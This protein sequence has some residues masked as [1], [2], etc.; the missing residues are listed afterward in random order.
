[1]LEGA[2][3]NAVYLAEQA[4]EQT[5]LALAQAENV[6]FPRSAQHQLDTMIRS[7]PDENTFKTKL[8]PLAWLEAY[9]TTFRYPRTKGS[10]S[11]PPPIETLTNALSLIAILLEALA[12]HFEVS[13]EAKSESAKQ[14]RPPR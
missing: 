6:H 5:V 3:R 4:L 1:M 2:N 13:I 12:R 14:I 10:I 11:D 8:A 7:L 9:A